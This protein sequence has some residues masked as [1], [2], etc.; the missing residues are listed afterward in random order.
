MNDSPPIAPVDGPPRDRRRHKLLGR[1]RRS[2]AHP[3]SP[4]PAVPPVRAVPLI[5]AVPLDRS[6]QR[7]NCAQALPPEVRDRLRL[8][9]GPRIEWW[10]DRTPG[11]ITGL[12]RATVLGRR[13]LV[14]AKPVDFDPAAP[15]YAL[16]AYRLGDAVESV[17]DHRP[18]P[19]EPPAP[20][21]Y[22]PFI[23]LGP[24]H[25]DLLATLPPQAEFLLQRPFLG[26]AVERCDWHLEGTGDD[27]RFMVHLAGP[28]LVTVG[29]GRRRIPPGHTADSA[30]WSLRIHVARVLRRE[31]EV[32][33]RR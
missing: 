13:G 29:Y 15:V 28:G 30:H 17:V 12:P 11:A 18:E 21:R 19:G 1:V 22:A 23:G 32:V 8:L 20:V 5:R 26:T 24:E 2:V 31:A 3:G 25:R 10:A 7:E 16:T 14:V 4:V 33:H 9:A 27:D 6:R